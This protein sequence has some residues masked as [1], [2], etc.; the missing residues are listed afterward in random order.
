MRTT[1][2]PSF[3][4]LLRVLPA[5]LLATLS[6]PAHSAWIDTPNVRDG[7]QFG[8][9]TSVN[10]SLTYTSNKFN[11]TL[12]DPRI[13]GQMGTIEQVLADQDRQD[14]D[15][16]LRAD[17]VDDAGIQL[18]ARQVLTKDLTL[19]GS[20]YLYYNKEGHQNYGALWGVTLDINKFGDITVG[21]GFTRLPVKQTDAS[22]ILQQQGTNIAVEY[23]AIPDL[24]VSAYHMLT[25]SQD[26]NNPRLGGWHKSNGLGAKYE[27]DISPR[28]KVTVAAGGAHSEGHKN[29]FYVNT[30]SEGKAY[31][32]SV[33]Y[34]YKDLTL[35]VDY[36]KASNK[37]NGGWADTIDTKVLGVKADYEFTPRLIG[38]LSYSR[39]IDDNSKPI[40]LQFL[41][42]GSFGVENFSRFPVFDKIR[43]D[44][45]KAGLEYQLYKGVKVS[46]SVERQ[47]TT[48][49]VSEGKFS[50]RDRL[51][52][53]LGTSF[54]F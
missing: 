33:G 21:D 41:I 46:A 10:P 5:S 18:V 44:R 15:K 45:H 37:Y 6:L 27:F 1:F 13:Y 48:N 35:A 28:H 24:T 16:R 29:P 47:Q 42:D 36:G 3:K 19:R 9:F 40:D 32:G 7:L 2:S 26:V 12:G 31:M 53:T 51:H 30:P 22:N 4:G 23:T 8:V 34:K 38:T 52:T 39:K 25:A 20:S 50:E 14:A 54:S 43:Q 49:Y 17:G 11:Y